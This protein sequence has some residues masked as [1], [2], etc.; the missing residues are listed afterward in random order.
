MWEFYP[1]A[2]GE[3]A[4]PHFL[5]YHGV[6][7]QPTSSTALHTMAEGSVS[8]ACFTSGVQ[9]QSDSMGPTLDGR[10]YSGTS[11]QHKMG[12]TMVPITDD[13]GASIAATILQGTW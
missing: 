6:P 1:R 5:Y 3:P 4:G 11:L 8:Q 7:S 13:G 10:L 12:A 9:H 2:P